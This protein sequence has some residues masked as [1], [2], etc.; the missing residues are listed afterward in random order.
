[1][2]ETVKEKFTKLN[3]EEGTGRLDAL[4][5]LHASI[6]LWQKGSHGQMVRTFASKNQ[7][8]A[9][10]LEVQ[11]DS[12]LSFNSA[13]PIYFSFSL[14]RMHYFGQV[15]YQ[16][17]STSGIAHHYLLQLQSDLFR[18]E[19]REHERFMVYPMWR[20]YAFFSLP[21]QATSNVT[22]MH[23]TNHQH[24]EQF[25]RYAKNQSYVDQEWGSMIG[26]QILDVSASGLSCLAN[27]S[28]AQLLENRTSFPLVIRLKD[29]TH[30]IASARVV[31]QVDYIDPRFQKVRMKKLGIEFLK[32]E[33]EL[34]YQ[35]DQFQSYTPAVNKLES[36]FE[37]IFT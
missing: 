18:T 16:P 26:L 21:I 13:I 7:G 10:T 36:S 25:V 27:G 5:L 12:P 33:I 17:I 35:I 23:R 31:H 34:S 19:K 32:P 22:S 15:K 3:Y 2:N 24:D 28:E 11:A 20:A 6:K 8:L 29:A 30:R 14:S 4:S 37:E 1:M 9:G